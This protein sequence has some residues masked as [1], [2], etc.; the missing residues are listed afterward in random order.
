MKKSNVRQRVENWL[1]AKGHLINKNAFEREIK[2][3][4]GIVQKYIKYDK[5]ISDKHIKELYKL[6]KKFREI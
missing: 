6:I 5:K 1:H 4:K 3:S 2:V